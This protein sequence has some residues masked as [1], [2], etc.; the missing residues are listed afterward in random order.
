MKFTRENCLGDD[1]GKAFAMALLDKSCLGIDEEDTVVD[2]FTGTINKRVKFFHNETYS[3][4]TWTEE[5]FDICFENL[6]DL[7]SD[8]LSPTQ[9][10]CTMF[11]LE[12]GVEYIIKPEQQ[13]CNTD[14]IRLTLLQN[15]V[16]INLL[17]CSATKQ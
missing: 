17:L 9:E 5:V 11:S 15:C 3:D 4:V 12:F 1:Y 14:S 8:P 7:F 13:E 16:K 6:F 2:L 10:E